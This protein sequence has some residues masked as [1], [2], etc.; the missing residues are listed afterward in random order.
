MR[1]QT[2]LVVTALLAGG[3]APVRGQDTA[4]DPRWLAYLGCWE[5]TS[6]AKS[7]LCV[8]PTT[9]PSSID[10]LTIVKGEITARERIAATGEH[11][12]TARGE[13]TGWRSAQWSAHGQRLYLR[14]EDACGGGT[15]AG[16]GVIALSGNGQ[17]LYIQ[18]MTIGGQT[19]VRVQRYRE[20]RSDVLLPDDVAVALRLDVS[21]TMQAR[22]V[23]A[24]PLAI[25]DVVEASRSVDVAVLEALLVERAEPFSLDAKRLVALADAGVPSRVIDLMVALSYPH[26]FAINAASR[27]GERLPPPSTTGVGTVPGGYMTAYD[28]FC[29]GYD[30]MYP[31]SSYDCSGLRYGYGR[32]YGYG[33]DWY[34]GGYGVVI[35][36]SGGGGS[37]PHGKVVNGQGYAPG[38]DDTGTK[39]MPRPSVDS[40]SRPSTGPSSGSSG[41]A[42]PSSSS[43]SGSS[44]R[45]AQPRRP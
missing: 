7:Q 17:L 5:T 8:V 45:T 32:G 12:Q 11:V 29:S 1:T 42:A 34:G 37:R 13:C 10:L 4:I 39:A 25:D 14:S 43:S 6:P 30:Y 36:P 3:A 41:A 27:Q 2:L 40:Q 28:P 22:A 18:S 16:T 9:D 24:A 15:A 44:G 19:G 33:F 23:A 21:S 20:A 31:Y 35:I 26:A 38:D